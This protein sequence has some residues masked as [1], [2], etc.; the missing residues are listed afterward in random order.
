MAI[1]AETIEPHWNYLLAIER[2]VERLARYVEFDERNFQCFSIEI[3]R[4]LLASGAEVDV[5]CKQLCQTLDAN[6]LASNI[7]Q[8]RD[9][10]KKVFPQIQQFEVTISRY[11]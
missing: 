4:I 2:D 1:L 11:G 10:I 7:H 9:E 3:A 8:Y 6:S 5:V